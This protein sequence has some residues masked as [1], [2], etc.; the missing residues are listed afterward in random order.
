MSKEKRND[1]TLKIFA[2][3]IAIILWSYVMSE[4]NPPFTS[5]LKNVNVDFINESALERQGLVVMEPKNANIKVSVS[6]RRSEVLQVSRSDIIAQVDLNGYSEGNVKVPVYVQVPNDVRIV[7]YSPK[8]ILFKFDKIIRKDSTVVVE[9]QGKIPQG[10]VLGTPEIKPQ[11]IYIE[12]P[13]TWINLVEKAI[14]FVDVSDKTEDIRVTVPIKVVDDEGNDVRGVSKDQNVVDIFIPVYQTKKVPIELQTEN[15]LPDNYEIVNVNI[16]PSTIE[17]KGKKDELIGINSIKTEPID[18]NSFIDNR[19]VPVKLEIPEGVSLTNP[20]QE[21]TINLNIEEN[22]TRTFDYIL[23]DVEVINMDS[24]LHIDEEELNKSFT[25]T[26]KGISSQIEILDE[27]DIELKLDLEDLEEG[28][29][30]VSIE[31]IV[32]DGIEIIS[33]LPENFDISLIKEE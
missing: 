5:E 12:G 27:E 15:Q 13:R 16:N 3:I 2:L 29:H 24:S 21:I 25:V 32:D 7:D 22:I 33:V 18:I 17:I 8:E 10:Y 26:V 19:N 11:S 4:V 14:A 9:T 23:E 28:T 6:G 31:T 30:R 20:N 1:L